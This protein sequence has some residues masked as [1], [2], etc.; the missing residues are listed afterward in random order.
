MSDK[1]SILGSTIVLLKARFLELVGK[2]E[3]SPEALDKVQQLATQ[4]PEVIAELL[5]TEAGA[6]LLDLVP[7]PPAGAPKLQ[8]FADVVPA[9]LPTPAGWGGMS[10]RVST[11]GT[12]TN[13]YTPADAPAENLAKQ[14]FEH[15]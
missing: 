11:A 1:D 8:K 14:K 7:L 3:I 9:K 13:A 6:K 2:D 4:P 15:H 10:R 12:K 5:S